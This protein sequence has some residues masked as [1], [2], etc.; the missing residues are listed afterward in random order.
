MGKRSSN[1]QNNPSTGHVKSIAAAF[2]GSST[3]PRPNLMQPNSRQASCNSLETPPAEATDVSVRTPTPQQP[4]N[5]SFGTPPEDELSLEAL[6]FLQTPPPLDDPSTS[7]SEQL[8]AADPCS[9]LKRKH[10]LDPNK[11]GEVKP[12]THLESVGEEDETS[13]ENASGSGN[14]ATHKRQK[15]DDGLSRTDAIKEKFK[16]IMRVGIEVQKHHRRSALHTRKPER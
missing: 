12:M 8:A 2:N 11:Y 13:K 1:S 16:K 15:T 5:N 14:V 3:I 9:L 7:I 4:A 6:E 10:F